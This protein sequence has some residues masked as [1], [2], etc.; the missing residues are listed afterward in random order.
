MGEKAE[1]PTA[2]TVTSSLL[3]Q[4]CRAGGSRAHQLAITGRHSSVPGLLSDTMPAEKV[5]D[6]GYQDVSGK[7]RRT[8]QLVMADVWQ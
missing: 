8:M 6:S 3:D 7:A 5:D 2:D 1:P 4:S